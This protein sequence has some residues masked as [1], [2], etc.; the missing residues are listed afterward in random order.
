MML[1][2]VHHDADRVTRLVTEL[3]DISRLETGRLV[4]RRQM[5]DLPA[6]AASVVEKV[7]LEYPELDAELQFP[8]DFPRSTPTPTRSSR[9]SPTWSRTPPSTPA[10]RP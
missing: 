2:Q 7:G 1:E 9:C 4:L 3:L 8:D 10:R 6:L 5:V